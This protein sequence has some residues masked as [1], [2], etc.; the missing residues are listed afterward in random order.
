M[1]KHGPPVGC[2]E[3]LPKLAF[4][5]F[6]V[7]TTWNAAGSYVCPHAWSWAGAVSS[8]KSF[9]KASFTINFASWVDGALV[10]AEYV[11]DLNICSW[12][13]KSL[14]PQLKLGNWHSLGDRGNLHLKKPFCPLIHSTHTVTFLKTLHGRIGFAKTS[15]NNS[16]NES[17]F[18]RWIWLSI[19]F[20]MN[21]VFW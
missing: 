18:V 1:W 12:D 17:S 11:F 7:M 20:Q 5:V 15:G 3:D 6:D 19:I 4:D 21:M 10:L 2:P 14:M 16:S 9:T 8:L 13:R